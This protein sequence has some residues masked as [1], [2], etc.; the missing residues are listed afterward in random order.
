MGIPSGAGSPEFL[1]TDQQRK[2]I[3]HT[4]G[5][6][7]VAAGP[8]TGKTRVIVERIASLV[9]RQI[10]TPDEI[11]ALTFGGGSVTELRHRVV[12]RLHE[13]SGPITFSTFHSFG[14]RL[15]RQHH[16]A[17]G[18]PTP[19][20]FITTRDQVELIR[21]TLKTIDA[22]IVAPIS[23]IIEH[24]FG[25]QLIADEITRLYERSAHVADPDIRKALE[26]IATEY[27]TIRRQEIGRASCRER[28]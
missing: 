3:D 28:V 10:A 26:A 21:R 7:L 2:V 11:L 24:R 23:R 6:L 8:G 5:P 27:Q 18:Y 4:A 15:L 13:Q 14:F 12:A 9:E 16:E 25:V 22:A 19:P 1:F 17:L 20:R